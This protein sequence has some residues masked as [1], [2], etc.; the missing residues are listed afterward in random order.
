MT[1]P[2]ISRALSAAGIVGT[3]VAQDQLRTIGAEKGAYVLALELAHPVRLNFAKFTGCTLKPGWYIYLGSARG[4]GGLRARLRRHFLKTK[5]MHWHV[6]RLTVAATKSEAFA[7]CGGDECELVAALLDR[8]EFALA[9]PGFGSTD[10]KR[11]SSHLLQLA[12]QGSQ[13]KTA[14][15]R[16][17]R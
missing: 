14:P 4:T 13:K 9:I 11:C 1:L 10:C 6:D 2:Q 8:P 7:V 12:L 3:R 16:G 15:E 17:G 5:K